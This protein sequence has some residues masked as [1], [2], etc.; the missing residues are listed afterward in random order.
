MPTKPIGAYQTE[1]GTGWAAYNANG[2]T[3]Q[4]EAND[5]AA[6]ENDRKSRNSNATKPEA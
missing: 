6:L 1:T 4:I 5:A 3:W 2:Q